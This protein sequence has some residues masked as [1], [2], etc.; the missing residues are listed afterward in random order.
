MQQVGDHHYQNGS[1][2]RKDL[3]HS[4]NGVTIPNGGYEKRTV[5]DH[6]KQL[7]DMTSTTSARMSLSSSSLRFDRFTLRDH[8]NYG[9]G[10]NVN[11][12]GRKT[13]PL[14]PLQ[15]LDAASDDGVGDSSCVPGHDS[16]VTGFG[17]GGG[18]E[19]PFID[20]FSGGSARFDSSGN[21]L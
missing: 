10:I 2:Y 16:P 13:L 11:S 15:P 18:R 7:P 3:L 14:F 8:G 21:G 1:V 19:Q 4:N 17:D 20:F 12:H 9:E 6:R 5:T